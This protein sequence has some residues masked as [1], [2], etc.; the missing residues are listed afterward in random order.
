MGTKKEE[1]YKARV[2]LS[3]GCKEGT[4]VVFL[5]CHH[6][7]FT[8]REDLFWDWWCLLCFEFFGLIIELSI[9]VGINVNLKS[10]K[11]CDHFGERDQ[12]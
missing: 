2:I 3:L 4:F 12:K 11:S 9:R 5:M 6:G 10:D 1:T 7:F 8:I